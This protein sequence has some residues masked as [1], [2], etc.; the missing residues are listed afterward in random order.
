MNLLLKIQF[1]FLEDLKEKYEVYHGIRI[2]DGAIVSAAVLSDR[3]ISDRFLPDK[4]IDL[5][6]EAAAMIRTEIDSMPSELDEL[7]RK[8]MQL[9]IER[10]ALKKEDDEASKERLKALEKELA[11]INANKAVLK[12]QWEVEKQ[13]I[14]K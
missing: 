14:E 7:T 11:E 5:I 2:S 6:D 1:Q 4:A 9:E 3:Y 10:E 12:S 8:S 13:E